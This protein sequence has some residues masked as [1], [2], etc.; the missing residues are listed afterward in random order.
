M[1]YTKGNFTNRVRSLC[2]DPLIID[3]IDEITSGKDISYKGQEYD[4]I[5]FQNDRAALCADFRSA[6][7]EYKRVRV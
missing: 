3:I 4:K 2:Y 7:N 1:F 6:F 5:N